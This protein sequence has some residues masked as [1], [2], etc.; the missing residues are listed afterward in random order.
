M[1]TGLKNLPI[2]DLYKIAQHLPIESLHSFCQAYP[3]LQR[4]ICEDPPL[5]RQ[6]AKEYLTTAQLTDEQLKEVLTDILLLQSHTLHPCQLFDDEHGQESIQSLIYASEH[7]YEIYLTNFIKNCEI[8]DTELLTIHTPYPVY[9][10][11]DGSIELTI[12]QFIAYYA[13]NAG[14]IRLVGDLFTKYLLNVFVEDSEGLQY[15][16]PTLC[17]I[18]GINHLP[19]VQFLLHYIE[20]IQEP[21]ILADDHNNIL[22][23][24]APYQ[25]IAYY[26]LNYRTNYRLI[27]TYS[28][29]LA[30]ENIASLTLFQ[31]Y[32]ELLLPG[33]INWPQVLIHLLKHPDTNVAINIARY[34]ASLSSLDFY[35][36]IKYSENVPFLTSE[37]Y[38]WLNN[39][40][41]SHLTGSRNNLFNLLINMGIIDPL[42]IVKVDHLRID[43]KLLELN[44]SRYLGDS[45]FVKF[46]GKVNRYWIDK[47]PLPILDITG[48]VKAE[49]VIPPGVK[50][51]LT[52]DLEG[53][54]LISM[55]NGLGGLKGLTESYYSSNIEKGIIFVKPGEYI[56]FRD[57]DNTLLIKTQSDTL[58]AVW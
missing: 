5:L 4:Q 42:R 18:N 55:V 25:D 47:I 28:L 6:L 43:R 3:Q 22:I 13:C 33:Q 2:E 53:N 26:L 10:T 24:A 40:P 50:Y 32:R 52:T 41:L 16:F 23:A 31:S 39:L 46:F 54:S 11:P 48:F 12:E 45:E 35:L 9:F 27:D 51:Y 57:K 7:G 30:V 14:Q 17:I 29:A 1:E 58:A 37:D 20:L 21:E 8:I 36:A 15:Y 44:Y 19:I 56:T 49:Q 34:I 38:N